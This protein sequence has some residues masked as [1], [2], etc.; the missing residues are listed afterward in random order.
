MT[1]VDEVKK[2]VDGRGGRKA[3][4]IDGT[5]SDVVRCSEG[6]SKSCTEV[7]AR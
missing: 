5:P 1:L 3:A 2:L 6:R 4:K 7:I